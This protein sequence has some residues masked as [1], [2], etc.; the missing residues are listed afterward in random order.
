[1]KKKHQRRIWRK[2]RFPAKNKQMMASKERINHHSVLSPRLNFVFWVFLKVQP[3]A[4]H[5]SSYMIQMYTQKHE[6][7]VN[8]RVISIFFRTMLS[9]KK[10]FYLICIFFW[11]KSIRILSFFSTF[12]FSRSLLVSSSSRWYSR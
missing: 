5:I 7:C 9:K 8:S 3:I 10:D 4:T 1:M 2:K 11:S 6:K 12:T